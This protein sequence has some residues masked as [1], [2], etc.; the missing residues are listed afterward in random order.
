MLCATVYGAV[1][2]VQTQSQSVY[3]RSEREETKMFMIREERDSGVV[4]IQQ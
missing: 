4:R 3:M 2:A 1:C